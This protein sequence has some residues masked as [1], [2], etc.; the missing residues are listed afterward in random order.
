[1]RVFH[2]ACC[3]RFIFSADKATDP[4]VSEQDWAAIQNFCEQVNTD[5]NG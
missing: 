2:H 3:N 5:P 4:S 1:M